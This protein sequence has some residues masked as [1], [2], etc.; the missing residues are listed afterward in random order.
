MEVMYESARKLWV[1]WRFGLRSREGA[2]LQNVYTVKTASCRPETPHLGVRTCQVAWYATA[3]TAIKWDKHWL[4][5]TSDTVASDT[6]FLPSIFGL[7]LILL[8]IFVSAFTWRRWSSGEALE[9]F[10]I[11][12]SDGGESSGML[13][14]VVSYK[15]TDILEV[16]TASINPSTHW[17]W[18]Q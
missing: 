16:L 5:D 14:R 2:Y 17:W 13:R 3:L 4:L 1:L 15:L 10:E 9:L 6:N 12:G 8:F 7:R 18:R 11:S